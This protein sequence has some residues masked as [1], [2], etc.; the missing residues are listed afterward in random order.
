VR[1]SV[2]NFHIRKTIKIFIHSAEPINVA[3]AVVLDASKYTI[4]YFRNLI[5]KR[6]KTKLLLLVIK[7]I[8]SFFD[9]GHVRLTPEKSSPNMTASSCVAKE[10]DFLAI[11]VY[12]HASYVG[13]NDYKKCSE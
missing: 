3:T 8:F 7:F 4:Y 11:D 12:F 1:K 13:I 6:A 5:L 9:M 10:Q 2:Y